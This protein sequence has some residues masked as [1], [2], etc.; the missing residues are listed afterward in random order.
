MNAMA[1]D[2]KL[3]AIHDDQDALQE[4]RAMLGA[5]LP[6]ARLVSCLSAREGLEQ[7]QSMDPDLILLGLLVPEVGGF[8]AIRLLKDH[9][10]VRHIPLILLTD[11]GCGA[12][13]KTRGL[14]CGADAFVSWPPGQAELIA[15]IR[16]MLRI[17][18]SEDALRQE[19]DRL[20]V[21]VQ[22]RTR[23]LSS[24]K[25]ALEKAVAL[26]E[27]ANRAKSDLLANMSHEIRTPLNGIMGSAEVLQ[28]SRLDEEQREFVGYI[29]SSVKNLLWV[30][31]NILDLSKVEAGMVEL[32]RIPFSLR[33][34]INDVV[35]T[36]MLPIGHKGLGLYLEIPADVK[37]ELIGDPHRLK[38]VVLNLLSNAVKFTEQGDITISV[39]QLAAE[40]EGVVLKFSV[41][42]TGIGM[43]QELLERVFAPFVQAE[44]STSRK[45]GGT[46]LGLTISSKLVQLMGGEIWA[47]SVEGVSSSFHFRLC[48]ANAAA[49]EL[50]RQGLAP[51]RERRWEGPLLH[52]LLAEDNEVDR[53]LTRLM[54]RELSLSVKSAC[55]G[56]EAVAICAQSGIDLVL[57]NVRMPIVDG[58][59]ACRLIRERAPTGRRLPIIAISAHALPDAREQF[60]G[61]G[62]DGYVSKP[63]SSMSLKEEIRHCLQQAAMPVQ[64]TDP[65][66]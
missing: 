37:D 46:G 55:N 43:K 31:N 65:P 28:M 13:C 53:R 18:R 39:T 7:A 21:L 64:K 42:D 19:R 20:E 1:S 63:F 59:E 10:A 57:M 48:F 27:A 49:K 66:A 44:S 35:A 41:K 11:T 33:R 47:E 26:A 45:Y 6:Q 32:E 56:E 61:L 8:E 24:A 62:F 29:R 14:A 9:P 54:L 3:L 52:V 51:E 22:E 23:E 5:W 60:L 25:H 4:L 34:C 38:Q 40:A 16:A 2:M 58:V 17:K 50:D 30:I 36:Q 15:Q 12:E